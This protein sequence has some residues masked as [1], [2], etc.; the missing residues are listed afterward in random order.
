MEEGDRQSTIAISEVFQRTDL[1]EDPEGST[2]L[3]LTSLRK[4][5]DDNLPKLEILKAEKFDSVAGWK[6]RRDFEVP[7]KSKGL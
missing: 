3:M 6:E 7:K 1:G 2:R 5:Y 4:T